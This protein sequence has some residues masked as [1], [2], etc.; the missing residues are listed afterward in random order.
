MKRAYFM[1]KTAG[2]TLEM[3]QAGADWGDE[4]ARRIKPKPDRCPI[5]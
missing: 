4:D 3:I 5:K 2:S 1:E